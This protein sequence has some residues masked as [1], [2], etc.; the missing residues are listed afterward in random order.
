PPPRP[1]PTPPPG[2][3]LP[4]PPPTAPPP[5]QTTTKNSPM[6][7]TPPISPSSSQMMA[8]MK[9][10][11]ASG[12]YP[13]FCTPLPNPSPHHPPDAIVI[14]DCTW[15]YPF[16]SGSSQMFR[17][18]VSRRIRYGSRTTPYTH[19][20]PPPPPPRPPP[21][22]PRRA[23][24]RPPPRSPPRAPEA[25]LPPQPRQH[26][27]HQQSGQQAGPERFHPLAAGIDIRRQKDHDRQLAKLG[28]LKA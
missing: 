1:A 18:P 9:S 28:W 5:S 19:P 15:W 14:S 2:P 21:P 27:D 10:V 11:R 7:A 16:P 23:P 26:A 4:P 3:I 25:P 12:R 6:P 20:R 22:P 8:K 13:Y 17:N 24:P